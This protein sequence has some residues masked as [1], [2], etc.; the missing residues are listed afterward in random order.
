MLTLKVRGRVKMEV[1]LRLAKFAEVILLILALLV[2]AGSSLA[3]TTTRGAI[4]GTV[5]DSSGAAVPKAKVVA[6]DN[7]TNAEQE[8]VTDDSGYYR[9]ATL[10]P[11]V[12]TVTITAE[13]FA[14]YKADHVVVQVGTITELSP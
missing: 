1:F 6:H 10:Q 13:G 8:T 7:G 11:A 4:G 12:Y 3:Q 5:Y 2:V 14:E 9:L